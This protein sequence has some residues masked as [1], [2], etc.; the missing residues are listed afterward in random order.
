M[1]AFGFPLLFLI[2]AVIFSVALISPFQYANAGGA[3]SQFN[4]LDL[5]WVAVVTV[6]IGWPALL[7]LALPSVMS[8]LFVT[9]VSL[10]VAYELMHPSEPMK[11]NSFFGSV[12]PGAWGL[13]AAWSIASAWLMY[14]FVW[15][16]QA[17]GWSWFGII[18]LNL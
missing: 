10:L 1:T 3:R 5:L 8:A 11:R 4:R 13:L 18:P 17:T 16:A 12:A 2:G 6:A 7:V 15:V 14:L 9:A